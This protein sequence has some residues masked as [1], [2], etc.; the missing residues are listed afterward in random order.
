VK[1][2]EIVAVGLR[3]DAA[4]YHDLVPELV[5][6]QRVPSRCRF[7]GAMDLLIGKMN[8]AEA[9]WLNPFSPVRQ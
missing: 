8:T 2:L 7:V 4:S 3:P 6:I 1:G 5:W 9:N